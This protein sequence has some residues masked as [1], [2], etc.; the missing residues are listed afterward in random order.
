[1]GRQWGRGS[2]GR[3][4]RWGGK[5]ALEMSI[6]VVLHAEERKGEER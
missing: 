1:M 2:E 5:L 6:G 4:K 3:A